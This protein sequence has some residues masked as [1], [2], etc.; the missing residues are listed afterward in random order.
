M[1]RV[2]RFHCPRKRPVEPQ[3]SPGGLVV[4]LRIGTHFLLTPRR[5][6]L[7]SKHPGVIAGLRRGVATLSRTVGTAGDAGWSASEVLSLT[8]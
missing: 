3:G 2:V 6:G 5:L 8:W 4:R 7:F 1:L